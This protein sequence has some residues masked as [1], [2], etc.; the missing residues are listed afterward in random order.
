M[1]RCLL[2]PWSLLFGVLAG[3]RTLAYQLRLL[4]SRRLPVPVIVVG[5]ITAGGTGKTPLT[6]ALVDWLRAA[7][8]RPGIVSRG[9]GGQG[10]EPMP[11]LPDSDPAV[12]GDE[13]VLLARRAGCPVW[14]GRRRVSAARR[15]LA[16]HPEVDLILAD[17]GLQHYALARDFEIV[18]VDGIRGLGN[19]WL[20][21]AGPLR[22]CRRRLERV[23]AVVV[24]GRMRTDLPGRVFSM[25][26]A[27]EV[28]RHLQDPSRTATARDLAD[29]PLHAVAGIGHPQRFF[30]HLTALGLAF[31]AHAFPDHH[32]FHAE[33]LPP[34]RVL[35][36]E[37]D[38][39]KLLPLAG[40]P[41]LS[42]CWYLAVDAIPEPGLKHLILSRI[43]KD[44]E[45]HHGP[46][47][48]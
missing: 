8:L 45:P 12:A 3:L 1:I 14:I 17:D 5:N 37:K 48:A 35:M 21:P 33:D 24:N 13:P 32:A 2:A 23:D 41:G 42:D 44:R 25:R 20:L 30:D 7:G 39:V 19:G 36:T 10:R 46:Q 22:E 4:R 6:L 31:T 16:M 15:L 38:A 26:L 9:H 28:F 43:H 47:V 11:V 40:E 18:V 34:G 27:G 29:R